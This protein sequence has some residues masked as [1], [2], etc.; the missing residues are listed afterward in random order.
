M[1]N[2]SFPRLLLHIA[3]CAPE[4]RGE[5]YAIIHFASAKKKERNLQILDYD[6]TLHR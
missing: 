2:I 6:I 4:M 5:S 3:I 1:A